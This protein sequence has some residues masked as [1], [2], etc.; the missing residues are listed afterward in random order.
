MKALVTG[1]TGFIGRRLVEQLI[2]AG[3][4][5]NAFVRPATD[6]S[7]VARGNVIIHR[8]DLGDRAALECAM[9]GCDAVFHLAAYARNWARNP[10]VFF[11]VNVEG[12][13]NVLE[14]AKKAG[15]RRMVHTSTNLVLEPSSGAPVTED[16]LRSAPFYTHYEESKTAAEGL[17]RNAVQDGLEAVIVN[18]T[19]VFGPGLVSEGNSVTRLIKMYLRGDGRFVL[20]DGSNVGNYAFV[21]DVARGHILAAEKGHPGERY[22]LGGENISFRGFY[23]MLAEASGQR[24]RI[25]CIPKTAARLLAEV[26]HRRASWFK[27][28]PLIS[29]EWVR[30][31]LD[32]WACS[33]DK[34]IRELGYVITPLPEALRLTVE[35]LRN[36]KP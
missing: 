16:I 8:G 3:W 33:S 17:V 1:S 19:R 36:G 20:G 9:R 15:V 28:Y 35:W 11:K 22:I 2:G 5:V 18:P 7:A 14:A 27:G 25:F 6:T 10:E 4:S 34:A 26:E 23:E 12:T 13:Q 29:P 21:E 32:D 30:L 24:H 31:F